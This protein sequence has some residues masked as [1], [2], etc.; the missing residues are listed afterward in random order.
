MY[1]LLKGSE[2]YFPHPPM[3]FKYVK[4]E[5]RGCA[6]GISCKF[7]HQKLC[8]VSFVSGRLYRTNCYFYHVTGAVTSST[9][10][11]ATTNNLQNKMTGPNYYPTPL[12]QVSVPPRHVPKSTTDQS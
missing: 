12:M 8:H 9:P 6:K 5:L 2:C 1:A 11:Y 10:I 4:K 7:A 3:C